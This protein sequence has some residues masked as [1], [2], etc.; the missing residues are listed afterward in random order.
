MKL[1]DD[2]GEITREPLIQQPRSLLFDT[3]TSRL[4]GLYV[5]LQGI[6]QVELLRQ[7]LVWLYTTYLLNS[8]VS[9]FSSSRHQVPV[10]RVCKD[11]ADLLYPSVPMMS[12]QQQMPRLK[13]FD[14]ATA[15][16]SGRSWQ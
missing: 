5:P 15:S 7:E 13:G 3:S 11:Q 9:Y 2:A 16:S 6:F 10:R 8:F 1:V 4:A 14:E 12:T